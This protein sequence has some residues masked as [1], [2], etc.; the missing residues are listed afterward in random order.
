MQVC[1]AGTLVRYQ[2]VDASRLYVGIGE[3]KQKS[4]RSRV[5]KFKPKGKIDPLLPPGPP[6]VLDK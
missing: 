2:Y 4:C 3:P 5:V 1:A 6:H